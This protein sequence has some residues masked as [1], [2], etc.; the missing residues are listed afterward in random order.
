MRC[1][2]VLLYVVLYFGYN[3][4]AEADDLAVVFLCNVCMYL[5]GGI[6]NGTVPLPMPW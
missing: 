3:L 1:S 6:I 2:S 5:I 4:E